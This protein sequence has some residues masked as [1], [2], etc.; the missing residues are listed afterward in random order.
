VK[1]WL[2]RIAI[3]L[4]TLVLLAAGY[5]YYQMRSRG[6]WR[7]PSY[8][9][10]PPEV[11]SLQ[12]PAVLVFSKTNSFIHT[13]AIPAAEN[14]FRR[15]GEKNGWS[16]FITEN[17][18]IHN[19]L[20]LAR[21][22]TLVWNNVTGNVLTD[23]QRSA[24]AAYLENGGGWLGI[25]AAGD[26][27][28]EASWPWYRDNLIGTT[29]I[30]H[31]MNPQFQ[32]ATIRIE[33]PGDPTV[34]HLGDEWVR[35]DEWYSFDSSP[36]ARGMQVLG[37]LDESTY[38]PVFFRKDIRMGDDHPIIWKNCVGEGRSF[39]SA[40]G[41]TAESFTEPEHV[42]MLERAVKWTAGLSGEDCG[43]N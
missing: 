2:F 7:I 30:G 39:Y 28:A 32:E 41:H 10:V 22:D 40:L 42:E 13:E 3:A 8:E 5:A 43:P 29:F 11:P 37:N 38:S 20:D 4:L 9:S 34:S 36:R 21:F 16:I 19:P 1:T 27:S 35:T 17:G 25:H 12:R 14:M 26:K 31:P 6:F 15:L 24:L 23:D 18:A 33:A